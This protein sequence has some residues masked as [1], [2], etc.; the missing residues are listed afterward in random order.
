MAYR[1][2]SRRSTVIVDRG[3]D[4]GVQLRAPVMGVDGSVVGLLGKV[5]EVTASTSKILL[6]SDEDF[7]VTAFLSQSRIEG[8][9]AG[10]GHS[11]MTVKY[12]PLET[13]VAEGEKVYTSIAS[14]I[15]P[16]GILI[17]EISYIPSRSAANTFLEPS[18]KLAVDPLRVK[19]VLIL[20][21]VPS[22]RA[23]GGRR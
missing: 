15:F 23:Q 22:A 9:A 17:G 3:W 7:F 8:L 16:D 12:L 4:H 14:A 18:L 1:E 5:V 21:P 6:S 2:P 13:P 19:E 11:A 10:N 20:D